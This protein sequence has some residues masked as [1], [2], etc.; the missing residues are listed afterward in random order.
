ME[1]CVRRTALA[2]LRVGMSGQGCPVH[3]RIGLRR[4]KV[5]GSTPGSRGVAANDHCIRISRF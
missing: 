3:R 5:L 4:L 1:A 2:W